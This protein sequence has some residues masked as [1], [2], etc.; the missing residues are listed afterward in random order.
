MASYR[1]ISHTVKS[2]DWLMGKKEIPV[3]LSLIMQ[4]NCFIEIYHEL[5]S[6]VILSLLLIQERQLSVSGNRMCISTV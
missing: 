2:V 3:L 1:L 6:M 5:F 4:Q